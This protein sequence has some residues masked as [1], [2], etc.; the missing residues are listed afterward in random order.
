MAYTKDYLA[1]PIRHKPLVLWAL[2]LCQANGRAIHCKSSYELNF[3]KRPK[4][5][6]FYIF[7][8]KTGQ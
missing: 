2:V 1:G 5:G 4:N 3:S 8:L 7:L 6:H